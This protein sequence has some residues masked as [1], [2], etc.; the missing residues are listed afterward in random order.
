MMTSQ[1]ALS[2]Y[3]GMADLTGQMLAAASASDWDRLVELEQQ[4]AACVRRLQDHEP[5]L[6][7]AAERAQKLEAIR[8]M[9]RADR[10][11]RDLTMPWMTRLSS[12]IKNSGNERRLAGAYGAV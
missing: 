4:C 11:I 12:L 6:L 9:L 3:Q 5:P 2:I 8:T 7:D 1:Q 10:Q